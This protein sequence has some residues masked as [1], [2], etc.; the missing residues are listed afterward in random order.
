MR[1]KVNKQ[2]ILSLSILISFYAQIYKFFLWN[3]I[4]YVRQVY[5]LTATGVGFHVI[6]PQRLYTCVL[7]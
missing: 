1:V 2:S 4:G 7:W 6:W 3:G 5:A